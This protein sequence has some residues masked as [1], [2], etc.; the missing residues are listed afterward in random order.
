MK[1]LIA[2]F[3]HNDDWDDG[4]VTIKTGCKDG[5]GMM[6]GLAVI[7]IE[8]VLSADEGLIKII[9]KALNREG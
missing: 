7:N 6:E 2:I 3:E 5:K 8:K 9:L 1:R 4:M